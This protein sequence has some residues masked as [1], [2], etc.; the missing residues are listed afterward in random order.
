MVAEAPARQASPKVQ[1]LTS[2]DVPANLSRLTA[3]VG[4]DG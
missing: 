1:K 4:P 3:S 2:C